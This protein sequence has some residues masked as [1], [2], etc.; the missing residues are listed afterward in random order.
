M[1]S[2]EEHVHLIVKSCWNTSVAAHHVACSITAKVR[3][4]TCTNL[5]PTIAAKISRSQNG[6]NILVA[7]Q[8]QQTYENS[9]GQILF[10]NRC[11][12]DKMTSGTDVCRFINDNAKEWGISNHENYFLLDYY[13]KAPTKPLQAFLSW[14]MVVV[15]GVF[16]DTN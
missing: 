7:V 1:T 10:Y 8:L 9:Y 16:I 4:W 6:C 13:R 3:Q 15:I 11:K 5:I 12:H 2:Q 14:Y